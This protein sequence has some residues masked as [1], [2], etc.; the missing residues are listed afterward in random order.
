M[1]QKRNISMASDA[2]SSVARSSEYQQAMLR[3]C[4]NYVHP[5]DQEEFNLATEFDL[6]KTAVRRMPIYRHTYRRVYEG[7]IEY[8]QVCFAT[9]GD[10][11]S[12]KTIIVAWKDVDDEVR[13]DRR[14]RDVLLQALQAA[15]RAN[16]SKTLF[17]NNMSHDIR[18]PMNGIIGM[19]AIA[20]AHLDDRERVQDCLNKIA[21]AS[22][23]LLSLINDVL[24]VSRIESGKITLNDETFSLSSHLDT[25]ISMISSRLKEKKLELSVVVSNLVHE[26]VIGDPMRLQQVFSNLSDNAIKYTPEGGHIKLTLEELPS[27]SSTMAEYRF[28]CQDDGYGMTPEFLKRVFEPFERA[29]DAR[30]RDIQGTGLGMVI[31]RNAI[32]MMDGDITAESEY[33]VGTTFTVTFCLKCQN[34]AKEDNAALADVPILV[35][36]DEPAICESACLSLDGMGMK[37]DFATSGAE[38]IEKVELARRA[39]RDYSVVLIDWRMPEMDGIETTRRI[40]KIVGPD[41][42][43]IIISA[44]DWS[45]IED[46]ALAA[47]AD[48][49]IAKPLFRSRLRATL[50]QALLD[51]PIETPGTSSLFTDF[52]RL[53]YSSKRILL[54]EDNELNREIA[55]EVIGETGVMIECATNG[56]EALQM[57]KEHASGYY[58]MIFMDVR[59]PVMDGHEATRAIRALDRP[60]AKKVPV[61]A[62]SANAFAEDMEASRRAGMDGHIAKPVDL[63]K[64]LAAM[65][66]YLG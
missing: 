27:T 46:E 6:V 4:A 66:R 28:T 48:A 22:K 25:M 43:L 29:D 5:E 49:F 40:R 62:M 45:D 31:A 23:H 55:C 1:V 52:S 54:V 24:D 21:G 47:G 39:E 10:D 3:Y 32:R 19:T 33:G 7:H 65:S 14:Q 64:L 53:N 50:T 15:E 59:M 20:R 61:L 2:I 9:P 30:V 34:L 63:H 13:E 18:T 56:A 41:C 8:F 57:F 38:A 11:F 26:N 58:G 35:V 51:E 37:S 42:T 12:S 44:Y 36:D 16:A 17:L 60:D